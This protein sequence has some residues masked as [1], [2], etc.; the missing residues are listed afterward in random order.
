MSPTMRRSLNRRPRAI[1]IILFLVATLTALSV[2]AASFTASGKSR[3][4]LVRSHPML[5]RI[6]VSSTW[7]AAIENDSC[8]DSMLPQH[9]SVDAKSAAV[10][11][12][13]VAKANATFA[14]TD[15]IIDSSTGGDVDGDDGSALVRLLHVLV[16]LKERL[17]AR[18]FQAFRDLYTLV[19]RSF[20]PTEAWIRDDPVGQLVSSAL[21]LILFFSGVAWFAV[22][23]I[24]LL[25]GKKWTGPTQVTV[26]TV[27]APPVSSATSSGIKYQKPKWN[28]PGIHTSY[29]INPKP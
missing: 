21:S 27:R 13:Y 16:S 7:V 9:D 8:E 26:P 3:L 4:P 22:W 5:Q 17:Y 28:F 29:D 25:G 6:S 20:R 18:I 2:P 24:E 10:E 23:N 12:D 11:T 19:Q 14:E 1:A 15:G